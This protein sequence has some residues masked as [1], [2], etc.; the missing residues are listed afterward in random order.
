MNGT[1]AAADRP[2]KVFIR[3]KIAGEYV[4]NDV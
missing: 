3:G 4:D 2:A 1:G